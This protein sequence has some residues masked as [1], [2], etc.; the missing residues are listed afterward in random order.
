MWLLWSFVYF[1]WYQLWNSFKA[2]A[3]CLFC[4]QLFYG[5][6]KIM[7]SKLIFSQFLIT[8]RLLLTPVHIFQKLKMKHQRPWNKQLKKHLFQENQIFKMWK[9]LLEPIWPNRNA[10]Y[11]K[12]STMWCQNYG[13]EK[14]SRKL[15]FLIVITIW[16]NDTEFLETKN[17][18]INCPKIVEIFFNATC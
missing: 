17:L 16:K 9:L 11:K 18:L 6:T 8:I 12:L 3:K 7:E 15:F 2:Y 10:Q 14:H 5:R 4:Q 1:K 13:Y